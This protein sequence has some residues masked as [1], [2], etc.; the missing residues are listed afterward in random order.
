MELH[1]QVALESRVRAAM[2]MA[3]EVK[4]RGAEEL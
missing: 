4:G 1:L 3:E 2:S